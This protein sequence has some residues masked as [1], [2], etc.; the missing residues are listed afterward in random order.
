MNDSRTIV[1]VGS[2]NADLTVR[3]PRLPQ[4][5]E[6]VPGSPLS[7]QPGGKSSNQAVAAALL[8]ASVHLVGAVGS[9]ANGRMLVDAVKRTGVDVTHVMT[10]P[11]AITGTA[12]IIVDDHAENVIV[13][14]A[15]ANGELRPDHVPSELVREAGVVCLAL[16]VP[17]PTVTFSAVTAA[18]SGAEVIL[19]L[20]PYQ[21]V[22]RELLEAT[23]LVILNEHELAQLTGGSADDDDWERAR[24]VLADMSVTRAVV[25]L[26]AAGCVV[27]EEDEITRL[28][29][30]KITAVDTTGSGDAFTGALAAGLASGMDLVASARFGGEAGAYAATGQGA[31]TS[32]A[33]SDEL[34][35]WT[36]THPG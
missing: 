6:T 15:G 10:P 8:G 14:S 36:S 28:P 12:V 18:A 30:P 11:E 16:E 24:A 29:A 20:S 9:D 13:I 32:Y 22:P 31:Q 17:L 2:L 4:G 25:T 33:T 26:G 3:T 23:S 5:G 21:P 35:A 1:V 27:I 34:C 7:V 19:N